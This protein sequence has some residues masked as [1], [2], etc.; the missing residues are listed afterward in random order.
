MINTV[1]MEENIC[2]LLSESMINIA[3]CRRYIADISCIRRYRY[4]ISWRNIDP[5]KFREKSL[6]IG[7][8]SQYVGDLA[9]NRRFFPIYHMVNA[10]KHA[11]VKSNA[12]QCPRYNTSK[13]PFCC[14]GDSNPKPKGL[15]F[16]SLTIR[17]SL[18]LVKYYALNIYIFEV[19]I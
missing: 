1:T 9:I 7:D 17:A 12:L 5:A 18:P 19:I 8:I 3:I 15:G 10:V 11:T 2:L 13:M 6:K 16:S 4:D 14:W